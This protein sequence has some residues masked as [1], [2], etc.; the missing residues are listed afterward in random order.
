MP[1]EINFNF[2]GKGDRELNDVVYPG[3]SFE[4]LYHSYVFQLSPKSKFWRFGIR[5][6]TNKT[7]EFNPTGRYI[8]SQYADLQLVVG[9]RPQGGDWINPNKLELGNYYFI[10]GEENKNPFSVSETYIPLSDV[11]LLVKHDI[12]TN[13]LLVS[14]SASG[15]LP[16]QKTL[17]LSDYR[18]FQIFAWADW[19]DFDLHCKILVNDLRYL[20]L[21]TMDLT[22]LDVKWLKLIY[23]RFNNSDTIINE[24]SVKDLWDDFPQQ[25]DPKSI[26]SLLAI[27]GTAI[28]LYGIYHIDPTSKIFEHFDKVVYAIRKKLSQGKIPDR[29]SSKEVSELLPELTQ[30]EVNI[31]FKQIPNF[32]GLS[33]GLT[34]EGSSIF[35]LGVNDPEVL[36]TYRSYPGLQ[37]LL[38]NFLAQLNAIKKQTPNAPDPVQ[39]PALINSGIGP[40]RLLR[41]HTSEVT[42]VLGVKNLAALL[43]EIIEELTGDKGQMIGI[44]G[45]WGR[46][47]TFLLNQLYTFLLEKEKLKQKK[48]RTKYIKVDYHAWKYQETPHPGRIY[49][50][51]WQRNILVNGFLFGT[52]FRG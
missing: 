51:Y 30:R 44:F 21:P 7:V 12:D 25:Y 14:Y 9:D 33:R 2:K 27:G 46:G 17:Q 16:F 50:R 39:I 24:H 32:R 38:Y 31:V 1:P 36:Q 6:S 45:K 52:T 26:P 34:E 20:S 3:P 37:D 35:Q 23:E 8:N 18:Y 40:T 48:E 4:L 41:K 43:S 29:I 19:I 47:K 42:P 28:T 22:D 10:K 11:T 13:S 5:L 49:M 15:C